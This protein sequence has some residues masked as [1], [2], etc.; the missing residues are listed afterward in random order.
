MSPV[1]KQH[2][3]A[4]HGA[5]VWSSDAPDAGP[6]RIGSRWFVLASFGERVP[7]AAIPG[8]SEQ[9]EAF[10]TSRAVFHAL[11]DL[12]GEARTVDEQAVRVAGHAARNACRSAKARS[13]K[14]DV[15]VFEAS[16]REKLARVLEARRR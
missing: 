5:Y 14:L 9:L 4:R 10:Y 12:L 6:Y 7:A 3:L 11:R 16:V 15:D 1:P 8:S 13:V 2:E